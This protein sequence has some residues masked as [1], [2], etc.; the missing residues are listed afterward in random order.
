MIYYTKTLT[1][2]VFVY[3][4]II[5]IAYMYIL[6]I[7]SIPSYLSIYIYSIYAYYTNKCIYHIG[8]LAARVQKLRPCATE[9][10]GMAP[11]EI[12]IYICIY[13]YIYIYRERE[14]E[15]EIERERE[16]CVHIY[17]YIYTHM[18]MRTYVHTYMHTYI[19][20]CTYVHICT[21]VYVYIYI[22]TYTCTCM[23]HI[24]S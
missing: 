10:L 19:H 16:L 20:T 23:Y 13:M 11:R 14:S 21:C 24:I 7:N 22:Y 12:D 18:R 9:W 4:C 1:F 8:Y 3:V 2:I 15:I 5:D 17:I 6:H